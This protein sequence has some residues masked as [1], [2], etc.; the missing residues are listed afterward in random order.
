MIQSGTKVVEVQKP[1]CRDTTGER[2]G[3]AM[4]AGGRLG[5]RA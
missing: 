2:P 1:S 3:R 5:A 4:G